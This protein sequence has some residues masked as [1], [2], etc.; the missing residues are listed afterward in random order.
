MADLQFQRF[1]FPAMA[2]GPLPVVW[3]TMPQTGFL[4]LPPAVLQPRGDLIARGLVIAAELAAAKPVSSAASRRS[5]SN[6]PS[7]SNSV[8]AMLQSPSIRRCPRVLHLTVDFP[9]IASVKLTAHGFNGRH[10]LA[11]WA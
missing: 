11:G 1:G 5:S 2:A 10:T 7:P 9:A 6:S 3:T 8:T 4:R